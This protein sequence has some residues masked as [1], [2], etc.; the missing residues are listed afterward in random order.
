MRSHLI[1]L[2]VVALALFHAG[3]ALADVPP[4]LDEEARRLLAVGMERYESGD[5]VGAAS[6][7]RRARGIQEHP[8]LFYA[9]AQA[10]RRSGHCE[11]A[12][13]LYER[14]LASD[15]P[16]AEAEL[17]TS[18]L[19]RCRQETTLQAPYPAP[20]AAPVAEPRTPAPPD[21]IVPSR[22]SPPARSLRVAPAEGGSSESPGVW[23][24]PWFWSA[25]AGAVVTGAAAG[26]LFG[27]GEGHAREADDA[28]SLDAFV[29]ERASV[30]ELRSAGTVMAIVAGTFLVAATGRAI[31]VSLTGRTE[32]ALIAA[33]PWKRSS[34]AP[35]VAQLTFDLAP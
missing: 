20:T 15:P 28:G 34:T 29:S 35:P 26:V 23:Q 30:D 33:P 6:T 24:D 17:A 5:F 3:A 25:A 7:F 19:V 18:N 21:A 4:A 8:D 10:E 14:F 1:H 22:R 11:K 32:S 12:I 2:T 31:W 27:V 13:G 9:E 16:T